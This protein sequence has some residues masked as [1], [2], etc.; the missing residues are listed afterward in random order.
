MAQITA[1]LR[2]RKICRIFRIDAGHRVF[3][4]EGKCASVH[5]HSY[6]IAVFIECEEL[7][8]IGRVIDFGKVKEILGKWLEDNLDH[9][10]ILYTEDPIAH[11]WTSPTGPLKDHKYFLLPQNPTAENL[12]S[13]LLLMFG[14]LLRDVQESLRVTSVEVWETPNCMAYTEQKIFMG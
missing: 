11:L 9:A 1:L 10:M 6:T 3:Q 14:R 2:Q 4:H 7:D 8:K 12:A 5:G 13:Y